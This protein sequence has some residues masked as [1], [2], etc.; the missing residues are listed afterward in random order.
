MH[1]FREIVGAASGFRKASLASWVSHVTGRLTRFRGPN[2]PG[3]GAG[4][5]GY[6]SAEGLISISDA[7]PT[8]TVVRRALRI[9][10]PRA[11]P[12]GAT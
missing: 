11:S 8:F 1:V 4:H 10:H 5:C 7:H 2:V 6:L 3:W 9:R 12:R